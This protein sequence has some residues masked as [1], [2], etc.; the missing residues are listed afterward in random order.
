MS[1]GTGDD[2]IDAGPLSGFRTRTNAQPSGVKRCPLPGRLPTSSWWTV[3]PTHPTPR[4]RRPKR[5]SGRPP[6]KGGR[7][8]LTQSVVSPRGSSAL[9]TCPDSSS[10]LRQERELSRSRSPASFRGCLCPWLCCYPHDSL[11]PADATQQHASPANQLSL[12]FTHG[13]SSSEIR[14]SRRKQRVAPLGEV[15]SRRG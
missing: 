8:N 15:G 10:C 3:R 14:L 12:A 11:Q 9:R 13:N 1:H 4:G 6:V 5:R 7:D 2:G